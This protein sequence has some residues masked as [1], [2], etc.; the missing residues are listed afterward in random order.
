MSEQTNQQFLHRLWRERDQGTF[1]KTGFAKVASEVIVSSNEI[2]PQ[3][4][5]LVANLIGG[6][7]VQ[8]AS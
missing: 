4:R 7:P 8:F 1:D 5:E 6:P 2:P 3:L